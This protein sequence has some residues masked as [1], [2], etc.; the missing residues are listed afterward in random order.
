MNGKRFGQG[1]LFIKE[2]SIHLN[3]FWYKGNPLTN[4]PIFDSAEPK[5]LFNTKY[6]QHLYFTKTVKHIFEC[7]RCLNNYVYEYPGHHE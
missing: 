5:L 2:E 1:E 7:E 3:C 4:I 6:S